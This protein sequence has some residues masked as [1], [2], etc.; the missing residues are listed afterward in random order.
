MARSVLAAKPVE[1]MSVREVAAEILEIV[2]R[3][4]DKKEATA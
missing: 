4:G 1:Q 3:N 2:D